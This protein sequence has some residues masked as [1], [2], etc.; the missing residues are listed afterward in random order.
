MSERRKA[1]EARNDQA[2]ATA[3]SPKGTKGTDA[4]KQP[5][6][7]RTPT[8]RKPHLPPG[9][10]SAQ[11][12]IDTGVLALLCLIGFAGWMPVLSGPGNIVASVGG[13]VFGLGVALLSHRF[14]L[15]TITTVLTALI[16]YFLLG[17]AI[18]LPT[19]A[20]WF[21]VP[22][23]ETIRDL[24]VGAVFSWADVLTLAAPVGAPPH[25]S[26]L[27]YVF[28]LVLGLLGGVLTLR[29]LSARYRTLWRCALVMLI[30]LVAYA[31]PVVFG[32]VDPF[33][34][35]A[36]GLA[37]AVTALVWLGWR[38]P[39][40]KNI[41]L[42]E[43]TG[44]RRA[45]IVG[46]IA[47]TVA[48]VVV[49]GL[50]ASVLTPAPQS[51]FVLRD[52]VQPPFDP[53]DFASP[54][55]GFR[56]YTKTLNDT[57]LMSVTGLIP[58]DRVR[59]AVMDTYDGHLWN[60]AGPDLATDGS[61]IFELASSDLPKAP[62]ATI[63]DQRSV[64]VDVLGYSGPW[65]PTVGV[66]ET[67]NLDHVDR[68]RA[69][70]FRFNAATGSAVLIDG[71]NSDVT[72]SLRSGIQAVPGD[73]SLEDTP[74]APVDMP[75]VEKIPDVVVSA[76]KEYSGA[77]E[78]P[79][80]Q[81]RAIETA[82]VTNGYLSHG[83]ESDA[84]SSRAGH[85][86]D[87]ME[88]LFTRANLIGDQEQYA[89]AMAL[90]ARSLGYPAR[91]VMGFEPKNVI[92]G[93]PTVITGDD[94]TAWVEVPFEGIG[95]VPFFPTPDETEIPQDQ[96]PKPQSEPQPQ[97]RQP[98]RSE[99]RPD[100]LLTDSDIDDKSDKDDDEEFVLPVWAIVSLGVLAGLLLLY[101]VPLAIIA[102]IKRRRVKRRRAGPPHQRASGA[103]DELIDRHAELG[104][105][106][107]SQTRS[108][109][110]TALAE[111]RDTDAASTATLQQLAHGADA[112]VFSGADAPDDEIEALWATASDQS[113]DASKTVG[114]WRRQ[115]SR[116]RV[117]RSD[118]DRSR[119]PRRKRE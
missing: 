19:E 87:R 1:R 22:T 14:R 32:T 98:P 42:S 51:R 56:S 115:V 21:V 38:R 45:R 119:A 108:T 58:G 47:V 77:A 76:A 12:W 97:V 11:S 66:P 33:F 60:V 52:L 94:V 75:P 23:L 59:L 15:N 68:E 28:A 43:K 62:L 100:D 71:V 57:D 81:L 37:V 82:L 34:P 105:Q 113:R 107:P 41:S 80:E 44:L 6:P 30:P 104:Y 72:Y 111:Q 112:A 48:A 7:A 70:G 106:V 9:T 40:G 17:S 55:S 67:M 103:W 78:S 69:S 73:D 84:A 20:R 89:S 101:L 5:K 93:S 46:T 102:L 79:I 13:L 3:R 39:E 18:A 26:V 92:E 24:A 63:V 88:E 117:R 25:V 90:M 35:A 29:W 91:V 54:L 61:G 86:A 85:G 31:L 36:R 64:T 50:A 4:A 10:V 65:L 116:F 114:W 109:V 99:K 8:P 110:A 96:N 49:G 95:W 74:V 83:L 27:P 53:Q 2:K 16:A 118:R